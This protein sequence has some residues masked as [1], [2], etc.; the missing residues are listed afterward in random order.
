[1]RLNPVT[2]RAIGRFFEGN[3]MD[4]FVHTQVADL[5]GKMTGLQTYRTGGTKAFSLRLA[6]T[7]VIALPG[8]VKISL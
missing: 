6:A 1:M 8:L 3:G 4:P 2:G 7:A 5:I